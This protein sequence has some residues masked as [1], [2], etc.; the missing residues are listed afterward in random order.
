MLPQTFFP[1]TEK[2]SFGITCQSSQNSGYKTMLNANFV[3]RCTVYIMCCIL[4][5]L[6]CICDTKHYHSVAHT[7]KH[8]I[9]PQFINLYYDEHSLSAAVYY[10]FT[11]CS[12]NIK[13]L[14]CLSR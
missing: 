10:Q 13:C 5:V 6:S 1:N 9:I 8:H 4:Y 14:V 12:F 3:L 11:F 2:L 7:Y